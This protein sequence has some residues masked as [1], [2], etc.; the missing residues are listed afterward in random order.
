MKG[1]RVTQNRNWKLSKA[2]CLT[3]SLPAAIGYQFRKVH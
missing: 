3:L 2:Q 1:V